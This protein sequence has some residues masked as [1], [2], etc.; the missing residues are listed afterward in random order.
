[1]PR[2]LAWALISLPA[3][4]KIGRIV[5]LTYRGR[6][7]C[8]D[9][10]GE[11]ICELALHTTKMHPSLHTEHHNGWERIGEACNN[12]CSKQLLNPSS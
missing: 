11:A 6:I 2:N 12:N 8:V 1:M 7:L 4:P 5:H 10:H 3:L 9:D